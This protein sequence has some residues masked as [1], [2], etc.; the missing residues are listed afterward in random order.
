[1]NSKEYK[2]ATDNLEDEY[3]KKMHEIEKEFQRDFG[4]M[5]FKNDENLIVLDGKNH[6]GEL[7]CY[8][9]EIKEKY[10]TLGN[11][12][13]WRTTFKTKDE[14]IKTFNEVFSG[15]VPKE[16]TREEFIETVMG[17]IGQALRG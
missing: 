5:Y 14:C 6:S 2:E 7:V 3:D 17:R 11:I 1:M 4:K 16:I 10:P 8:Y 9:F 12:D 13:F 15:G